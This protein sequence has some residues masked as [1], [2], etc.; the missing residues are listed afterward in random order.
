MPTHASS[1]W[2][3]LAA[4]MAAVAV[5]LLHETRDTTFWQDEWG[6]ALGRR[7]NGIGVFLTPYNG[8]LN[9]IPVAIYKLLFATV[10]LRNY[11]PY[12]ALVIAGHL[13]CVTLV[14]V[15][16]VR[17]LGS[18]P[19]LIPAIIMLVFGPGWENII[20]P[21]QIAWL[22]ALG[23]G[24][25]ALILID[26]DDLRADVAVCVLLAISLASSGVGLAITLG[27]AVEISWCRRR[28]RDSWIFGVPLCLYAAWWLTYQN[29]PFVAHAITIAPG[30]VAQQL[31]ATSSALF[32][33]SGQTLPRSEGTLL[34][35]G[36]TL[37][38][39]GTVYLGWRM[40]SR[41]VRFRVITLVAITL[42]FSLSTALSGHF[43]FAFPYESRYLYVTALFITLLG[44]ELLTG[45]S[46]PL[47][48]VILGGVIAVAA[49]I[50][51][52]EL[53]RE[54]GGFLRDR[55]QVTKAVLGAIDAAQSIIPPGYTIS[56]V[57]DLLA[58]QPTDVR[59]LL[60]AQ[61]ALGSP[62]ARP[63][64][65]M[66][67]SEEARLAADTQLIAIHRIAF[68]RADRP[69]AGVAPTVDATVDGR[70]R[71]SGS[72]VTFAPSAASPEAGA[73][74]IDVT[75]PRDGLMFAV[76]AGG[77]EA[78]IRRFASDFQSIGTITAQT[79]LLRIAPDGASQPWHLRL[80]V[81]DRLRICGVA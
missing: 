5:V 62:A 80:A 70:S 35:W 51:N 68:Q 65:I 10:G 28:L 66:K 2:A 9:L 25:A 79:G 67:F 37:L 16:A 69:V 72:C 71:V 26:R 63:D 19:A 81:E 24:I 17:R 23:S 30:W 73:P 44:V 61:R 6:Y 43:V 59:P 3:L 57:P 40:G 56:A 11:V 31:A 78:F 75:V 64:Q 32:G 34:T 54:A 15:Y 29:A 49:A 13:A 60:A 46:V 39:V 76:R 8:H 22:L 7:G 20:W 58:N 53:L 45:I 27:V 47:S 1:A 12:R 42:L 38:I 33:L 52:S 41:R 48:A 36:P 14:Y 50:S 21:F 18:A 4:L 55:G 77:V 74:W